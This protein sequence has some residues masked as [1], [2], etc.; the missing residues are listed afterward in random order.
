MQVLSDKRAG[1]ASETVASEVTGQRS[2]VLDAL[3]AVAILL[4]LGRH[5]NVSAVWTRIG[6]CGVDLFF[7]LSGF[8]ISG[9]LFQEYKRFGEI[10]VKR[11]W[12][13]RGLK[14]YPAY[15]IYLLAEVIVY[16]L[17]FRRLLAP[18]SAKLFW[19]D[20]AFL[21]NYFATLT[22]HAWSL[23]VEEHFYFLLPIFLLLLIKL[24]SKKKDPFTSIP[25]VFVLIAIVSLLLRGTARPANPSD[26]FRYLFPTH[27]RMD[28]L[29]C[30]V[31]I[32][33]FFHF[34][35]EILARVARWPLLIAGGAL[36]IPV[37]LMEIWR[38]DMYSWGLT[39]TLLGFACILTWAIHV[40]LRTGHFLTWPISLLARLG[41]YSYS[42]Y[43]WHWFVFYYLRPVVRSQIIGSGFPFAWTVAWENRQ[44]MICLVFSVILGIG[45]ALLIEQPVLRL[46]DRWFPSRTRST[47]DPE[48]VVTSVEPECEPQ[49]V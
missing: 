30:G 10:R 18:Q 43:L 48:P 5:A 21:S 14:I 35:P 42:I 28:A 37:F 3:R 27:L 26:F 32:G 13:R 8:L 46:R 19:I 44:W 31:T 23:A 22:G 39:C 34:K 16:L 7:V 45:M 9:L 38:W 15:Y 40:R 41:F 36:L 12:L 4:V 6:W 20:A 24:N 33:Y 25:L 2:K 49:P 1:D 47:Q 17:V 11:F 29:F